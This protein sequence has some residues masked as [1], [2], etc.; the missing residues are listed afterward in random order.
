MCTYSLAGLPEKHRCPECGLFYERQSSVIQ[1]ARLGWLIL[2]IAYGVMLAAG[3]ALLMLR[4][5]ISFFLVAA[6]A[7]MAG[8]LW[9]LRGPRRMVLVSREKLRIIG[10]EANEEIYAMDRI[11]AAKWSRVDGAVSIFG[12]NGELVTRVPQ[13]FLSSAKNTKKIAAVINTYAGLRGNGS[14]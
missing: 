6:A 2:A 14:P 10:R 8:V 1:R 4:G 9:H 11:K 5:K 3:I 13:A 7:G 12:T